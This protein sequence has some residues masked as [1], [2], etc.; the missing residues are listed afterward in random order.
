MHA[1]EWIALASLIL[2]V[3]GGISYIIRWFAVRDRERIDK[4]AAAMWRRI[5]EMRKDINA[6]QTDLQVLHE[7]VKSFPT[8][9]D[10]WALERR[11]QDRMAKLTSD[12]GEMLQSIKFTCPMANK[13]AE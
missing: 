6:A 1:S 5:D 9:D 8:R 3:L 11:I 2:V 13:G 12:F 4:E 10:I 7:T